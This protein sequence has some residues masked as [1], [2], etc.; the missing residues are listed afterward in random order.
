[1]THTLRAA[2]A[3]APPTTL[4]A[5]QPAAWKTIVV[6]IAPIALAAPERHAFR[7]DELRSTLI[8]DTSGDQVPTLRLV[9]AQKSSP[10]AFALITRFESMHPLRAWP[11]PEIC[12][13]ELPNR[14]PQSRC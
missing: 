10:D 6:E 12:D 3:Y 4:E 13:A 5:P 9:N 14:L 2:V 7:D 8:D 11:A 1:M